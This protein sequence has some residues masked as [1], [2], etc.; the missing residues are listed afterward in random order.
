MENIFVF[1]IDDTL[2]DQLH[3]FERAVNNLGLKTHW[4]LDIPRLYHL[5]K[6]YGDE[7]FSTTGFD[8]EK[9]KNMQ[10]FRIKQALH[11]YNIEITDKQAIKFQIDFENYQ[12]DII[13]F[14]EMEKLFNL[15]VAKKQTLG[16][17]TNGTLKRQQKK[18]K[19]LQLEKW[20]PRENILISE[21]VGVSKPEKLIFN[22]FEDK[23]SDSI[24]N[25][26]LFYIGDN[27]VNDIIGANS[28]YWKTIW[29][30]YRNYQKPKSCIADYI[31]QNP[32]ELYDTIAKL[33][34]KT[35][36]TNLDN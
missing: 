1:D 19:A 20:V 21:E 5:M 15:L 28:V 7:S 11:D 31:V 30:N 3:A 18:I 16:I 13:L 14:P 8:R 33:L 9:L 6:E 25:Q 23:L 22:F 27:Y 35:T 32:V 36:E 12:N 26:T 2:Y 34:S 24:K 29:V 4:H 17:I 10:I